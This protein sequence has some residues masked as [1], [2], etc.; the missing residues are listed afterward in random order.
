MLEAFQKKKKKNE[1][2]E[3]PVGPYFYNAYHHVKINMLRKKTDTMLL[4]SLAN[5]TGAHEKEPNDSNDDMLH[6]PLANTTGDHEKKQVK[7]RR[8][9]T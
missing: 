8:H 4:C 2:S 1:D 7:Q 6:C 9:V 3:P 5:K